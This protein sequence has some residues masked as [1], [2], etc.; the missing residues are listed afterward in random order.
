MLGAMR[1]VTGGVL[2]FACALAGGCDSKEDAPDAAASDASTVIDG[3][4]DRQIDVTAGQDAVAVPEGATDAAGP[5]AG[6]VPLSCGPGTV[7]V[8]ATCLPGVEPVATTE[9]FTYRSIT[10]NDGGGVFF[11]DQDRLAVH[12]FDLTSKTFQ[13]PLTLEMAPSAIA[14]DA[15]G[16]TLFLAFIGGRIDALDLASGARAFFAAAPDTVATM[17]VLE[18][19]LLTIDPSGGWST[20]SLFDLTSKQRVFSDDGSYPSEQPIYADRI[21]TVISQSD[22]VSPTDL[23]VSQYDPAAQTLSRSVD[24]PYHGNYRLGY[25]M[26]LTPSQDRLV[27]SSGL[28]FTTSKLEYVGSI[29]FAYVDLQFQGDRLYLL[30]RD[31]T[32]P[33]PRAP[34]RLKVLDAAFNVLETVIIQGAPIRLFVHGTELVVLVRGSDGKLGHHTRRLP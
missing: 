31:T 24:S 32:T 16:T 12:R 20:R 19:H 28:I 9:T 13:M 6:G 17:L 22:Q 2:V 27:T 7:Q 33:G 15:S 1:W 3:L 18:R 29:G 14:A 4:A 23:F 5:D 10:S 8:G 26:R 34:T 21:K 25:P 11:L 30:E